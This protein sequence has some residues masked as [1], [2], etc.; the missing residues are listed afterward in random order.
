M[1]FTA[2][3]YFTFM[4]NLTL[5][6]GFLFEMPLVMFLTRL[7]IVNPT[8]LAKARKLSYFVL[9]VVSVLI[10][11]PDFM[12]DF[13]VMIPLL[14]LYEISVTLSRIVYRKKWEAL[15]AA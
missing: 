2:D 14:V 6:F 7:G 13:L 12:S 8:R 15:S 1:V 10:T 4:L 5:P 9:I 11:P 3:K